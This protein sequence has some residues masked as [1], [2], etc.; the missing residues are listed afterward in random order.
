MFRK[1]LTIML[2]VFLKHYGTNSNLQILVGTIIVVVAMCVQFFCR[3]FARNEIDTLEEIGLLSIYFA[4]FVGLFF[5]NI[6][7]VQADPVLQD[8]LMYL[9]IILTTAFVVFWLYVAFPEVMFSLRRSRKPEHLEIVG[10]DPAMRR[11]Q[12]SGGAKVRWGFFFSFDSL[13]QFFWFS[14]SSLDFFR[15]FV[16]VDSNRRFSWKTVVP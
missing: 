15:F 10:Q 7:Q 16:G 5:L 2:A 14:V 4:F 13:L 11:M 12:T 8:L 9:V 6:E 3:P 1:A